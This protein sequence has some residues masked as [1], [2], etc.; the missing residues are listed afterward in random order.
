METKLDFNKEILNVVRQSIQEA[1]K[2]SLCSGYGNSPM[3]KMVNEVV[4][5]HDTELRT[6]MREALSS[7]VA[8]PEFRVSVKEAF[9]HK[10]ARTLVENL[11][12]AVK[13]AADKLKQ[14]PTIK[15]QMVLAIQSIVD[16]AK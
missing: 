13:Q 8:S 7:V 6:I 1:I 14:D 3:I 2:T 5:E 10:V 16:S 11:D 15:A 9:L 12:G 4:N